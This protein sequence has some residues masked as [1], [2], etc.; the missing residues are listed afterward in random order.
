[1]TEE[2]SDA[3]RLFVKR[4]KL[5]TVFDQDVKFLEKI[6][7]FLEKLDIQRKIQGLGTT[8]ENEEGKENWEGDNQK[9][10]IFDQERKL[11]TLKMPLSFSRS[12][13][14]KTKK[15]AETGVY[16][17]TIELRIE[18]KGED[19]KEKR[20]IIDNVNDESLVWQVVGEKLDIWPTFIYFVSNENSKSNGKRRAT[21]AGDTFKQVL[22]DATIIEFP[23]FIAVVE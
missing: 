12:I 8:D 4:E 1:M 18:N 17:W 15:N 21:E 9:N 2:V 7:I 23:T 10:I 11:K 5:P 14:N 20:I 13:L 19:C 16:D 3:H 22:R 6:D